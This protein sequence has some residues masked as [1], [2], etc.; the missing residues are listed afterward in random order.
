MEDTAERVLYKL[1][2]NSVCT[3]LS[4]LEVA[5]SVAYWDREIHVV[6][7]NIMD[8]PQQYQYFVYIYSKMQNG[9]E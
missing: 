2:F 7:F 9:L 6:P 3:V 5:V 1:L 8:L 4:S